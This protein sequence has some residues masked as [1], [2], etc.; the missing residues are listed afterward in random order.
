MRGRMWRGLALLLALLP[1]LARAEGAPTV[2]IGAQTL[3]GVR[4]PNGTAS[5]RGIAYARPPVGP[6]RWRPPEPL[7]A[8]GA[9]GTVDAARFAPVCPQGEGNTRWYRRVAAAMGADAA[10]VPGI[11][12]ISEDCLYLNVWT[13][14]P[15]QARPLPVLV[16]IHGG[17]NENGY[18]YEPNYR[19][20][21]L[22]REGVVVV[23]V[24]Y[25]LGLL[26]FF[27]HPALGADAG[28]RQG[29]QDQIAALRWVRAHIAAF[30]GDPARVTLVGESAG[31]I[32]IAVLAT[33]PGAEKLFARAV[34]ESGYLA[35]DGV[36]TQAEAEAFARGL[37]DPAITAESLRA[38]PWQA[39]VALQ[40]EKLRGRFHTPVA[41]WPRR[42]RVPLLIGS[43]ADEYRMYLPADEPGLKAALA[44]ELTGL[45]AAKA[46]LVLALIDRRGGSLTDRVEAVSSG[47]AFHCPAARMAAATS[48]SGKPVFAYRFK[49]VR[50]GGHGLGAYHG[51]E[52]PY[53]FGTA[54][55][56]LPAAPQDEALNRQ[57][58]QYWLNFAR[59]GDP[60]GPG[61][62][63]WPR[64]QGNPEVLNFGATTAAG[65][66]PTITL[67]KLLAR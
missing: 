58:Q 45:P 43:N 51:A 50:P 41:P 52:I 13:P 25:R 15:A 53:V 7:P 57:M 11:E 35:P 63:R 40:D 59:T 54:D 9:T 6:L 47:K 36:T 31:G 23:S 3:I 12:R 5:F 26:G 49:R 33:M 14:Q 29:L 46:K 65:K 62:P 2:R 38:L 56:W 24:A 60:N 42:S 18:A 32:D 21:V 4:E 16:W 17:S 1:G 20:D 22:A 28:G 10:V 48:A 55:A 67:C 44:D 34:I 66:I 27:A 30:G 37:F 61:L 19:G 8:D 64:F 39:L